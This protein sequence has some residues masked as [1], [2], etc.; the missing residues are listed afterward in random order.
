MQVALDISFVR[1]VYPFVFKEESSLN[2]IA[3]R[4]KEQGTTQGFC[5]DAG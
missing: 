1:F 4:M 2:K 5:A 3:P